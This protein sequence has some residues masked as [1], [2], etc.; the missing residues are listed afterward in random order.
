M[1]TG[2]SDYLGPL[3]APGFESMIC[4]SL[5]EF[6]AKSQDFDLVD[7]HQIRDRSALAGSLETWPHH[8]Q[9]ECPV[10]ELPSTFED[11]LK[12][13]GK[14][15]RYDVNK[16]FRREPDIRTAATPEEALK[17]L[18]IFVDLHESRWK[19]RGLPGAFRLPKTRAFHELWVQNA[20]QRGQLCLSVLFDH[21]QPIGA[22][23][24]MAA[25]DSTFFY[26][27]GFAPEAKSLSPGTVLVANAIRNAIEQGHRTFD[28]LRGAEPY[29]LRWQPQET[30]T[31][32][33]FAWAVRGPLGPVG[34]AV[35]LAEARIEASLRA[36][37][38]GRGLVR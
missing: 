15:L 8:G 19:N 20:V 3:C 14:S 22:L 33:R 29:K 28:F 9:A 16:G 10:L 27:S 1:G 12:L 18:Q 32:L 7:L 24:A 6:L 37:L 4:A 5:A 2:N 25:G 23:Y 31:N 26:Q 13:L 17:F 11:Y 38:E 30:R 34:I 21:E 35:N 36:R